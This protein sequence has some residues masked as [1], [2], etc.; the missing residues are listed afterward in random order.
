MLE[1]GASVSGVCV[2]DS[3]S[4]YCRNGIAWYFE[5]DNAFLYA[6]GSSGY[7][8]DAHCHYQI[9]CT[10]CSKSWAGCDCADDA[11]GF[12]P[13]ADIICS[14]SDCGLCGDAGGVCAS[15]YRTACAAVFSGIDSGDCH[16][17]VL[18]CDAWLFSRNAADGVSIDWSDYRTTDSRILRYWPDFMGKPQ[19][20]A[21]PGNESGLCRYAG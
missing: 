13:C 18:F 9:D 11:H 15:Q 21:E 4:A 10:V 19:G 8:G 3:G 2:S 17:T 12:W 14:L 7:H 16:C 6:S 5:Y 1:C 20:C